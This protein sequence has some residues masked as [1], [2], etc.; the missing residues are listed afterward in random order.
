MNQ[1]ILDAY[2]DELLGPAPGESAQAVAQA[3]A[4]SAANELAHVAVADAVTDATHDA[5]AVA[6]LDG[7]DDVAQPTTAAADGVTTDACA[8]VDAGA[9]VEAAVDDDI[10]VGAGAGIEVGA[11]APESDEDEARAASSSV[12]APPEPAFDAEALAAA[13]LEEFDRETAAAAKPA[14]VPAPAAAPAAGP[15]VDADL[16]AALLAEFDEELEARNAPAKP[17]PGK[18]AGAPAAAPAARAGAPKRFELPES[19]APIPPARA[20]DTPAPAM[21][22][23]ADAR[24][25]QART[26]RWLRVCVDADRYAVELLSVQEVVRV[27]P[28]VSMR[29]A[30]AAVLGVMN[31]RGRIVPVFDLGLWLG[32]NAV[33]P[34]ERSRIVVVERNDELIG[35]LVTAVHDVVTLAEAHIEPPLGA[36]LRGAIVGVA[37]ADES[38]TVLLDANWLFD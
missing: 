26:G 23:K 29:G 32:T 8:G 2:L 15:E 24:P 14:P 7:Y 38:P 22:P 12:P 4:P 3:V 35:L 11:M 17:A 19:F 16:A 36:G 5:L 31:L 10:D 20:A 30:D 37:R 1:P 25:G 27:A 34:D 28:I 6:L 21:R 33:R 18:P 9:R 13:L